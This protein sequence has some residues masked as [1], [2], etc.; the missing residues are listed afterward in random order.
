MVRQNPGKPGN[1][2]LEY[3]GGVMGWKYRKRIR[4]MPGFYLNLSKSGMSATVGV[5]GFSVNSGRNGTYLNAGIPGTGVYDRIR[6]DNNSSGESISQNNNTAN[7]HSPLNDNTVEIKSFQ[8]ELLSS[9]GLY[10]IKESILKAREIKNELKEESIKAQ[11]KQKSSLVFMI[12]THILI[13]GI[14][15]KRIRENYKTSKINAQEA[16]KTYK[17]FKMDIDFNMDQSIQ[18]DYIAL[19]NNFE[20]LITVNKIWDVTSTKAVDRIKERSAAS[21]IITRT[22]VVFSTDSLDYINTKYSAFKFQ[23]ANGGNL[24]IYPGFIVMPSEQSNDFALIDFRDIIV[25]HYAQKFVEEE[26]VPTDAQVVGNTWKHVKKN[27][28]PDKRYNYNPQIPI[29]C[30]YELVLKSS[31]GLYESFQF[32]N[33]KIAETFCTA[34]DSYQKSLIIMKWNKEESRAD[35]KIEGSSG[36]TGIAG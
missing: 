32:S 2:A 25:E 22:P 5:K 16:E 31:K 13:V 35:L 29:V 14:F 15:I 8:P 24:Y 17:D 28:Y 23:N 11:G 18:N 21:A 7:F 6:L 4:V 30:Y 12:I 34:L 3:G 9:D 36:T 19:K 10:E 1:A 27:G 20:K 26:P 33:V